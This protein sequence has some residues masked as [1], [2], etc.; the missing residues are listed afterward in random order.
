MAACDL[1]LTQ[2]RI[3]IVYNDLETFLDSKEGCFLI[4]DFSEVILMKDNKGIEIIKTN[5]RKYYFTVTYANN[6]QMTPLTFRAAL[7]QAAVYA[8]PVSSWN[9]QAV[10][11]NA[12]LY[13]LIRDAT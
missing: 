6:G 8:L 13:T 1:I 5:G 4:K 11:T 2:S 10:T 9:G 3:D 7:G 12:E